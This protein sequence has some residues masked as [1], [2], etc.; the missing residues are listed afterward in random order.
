MFAGTIISMLFGFLSRAQITRYFSVGEY[1]VFN[2]ALKVL[3]IPLVVATLGF[4]SSLPR[5]IACR[6]TVKYKRI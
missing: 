5:E 4:Q 3:N 1:R 2:L 6:R